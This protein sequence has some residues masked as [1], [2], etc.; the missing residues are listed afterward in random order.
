MRRR[1]FITVVGGAA[2]SWP[3]MA[4]AQ[5]PDRMRRIG[6]LVGLRESDPEAQRRTAAFV[7]EHLGWSPGGN[8]QIDYRWLSDSVERNETYAQELTALKPDVL[9][10]SSTPAV[11][12]L[13][14][15]T[16]TAT[17]IVF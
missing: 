6:W 16:G 15:K 14:Q 3:L 17:P 5:Q 10:T 2:V 4:H 7:L 11:K 1:K 12:A 13:R 8:I 9:V